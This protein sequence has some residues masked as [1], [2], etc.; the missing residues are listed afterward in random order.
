MTFEDWLQWNYD[1]NADWIHQQ[2]VEMYFK[3][4]AHKI[5]EVRKLGRQ[6]NL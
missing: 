4:C 3:K 2:W 5:E 1:N 6:C